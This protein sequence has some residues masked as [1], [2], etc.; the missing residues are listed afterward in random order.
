MDGLC[1]AVDNAFGCTEDDPSLIFAAD[2]HV[3]TRRLLAASSVRL[4]FS[5]SVI[6]CAN[7]HC[8]WSAY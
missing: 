2:M 5:S 4:Y 1:C 8:S 7:L 6:L 3:N